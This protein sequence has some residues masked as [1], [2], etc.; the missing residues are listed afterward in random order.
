MDSTRSRYPRGDDLDTPKKTDPR[1][2]EEIDRLFEKNELNAAVLAELKKKYAD[3]EEFLDTILDIY[4]ERSV[5]INREA[6]K[7][8]N[9]IVANGL[10]DK[11]SHEEILKKMLKY[12]KKKGYSDAQFDRFKRLI[13]KEISY[14]SQYQPTYGTTNI[15][16]SRLNKVLGSEQQFLQGMNVAD[17][18]LPIVNEI[19]D[20][21]DT[22][23]KLHRDVMRHALLYRDCAIE[24]I[25]G[26]FDRAKHYAA[27]YADPVFVALFIPRIAV[28][29]FIF[30]FS[31]I[32]RIIK[33]RYQKKSIT[34]AADKELFDQ[35]LIDPNDLICEGVSPLDD[36]RNRYQVQI[37]LWRL[38]LKLRNGLFFDVDTEEAA[39]RKALMAC[40][41]SFFDTS[42]NNTLRDEANLLKKFFSAFSFRPTY[43]TYSDYQPMH[44][45]INDNLAF[46][47]AGYVAT[48]TM[49]NCYLPYPRTTS[50]TDIQSTPVTLDNALN[51]FQPAVTSKHSHVPTQQRVIFSRGIII[52]NVKRRMISTS[53]SGFAQKIPFSVLPIAQSVSS[54]DKIN[55]TPV[56]YQD[57]MDIAGE[58][59]ILR[60]VVCVETLNPVTSSKSMRVPLGTNTSALLCQR[61]D[62]DGALK[63]SST[64]YYQYDP[65]RAAYAI[66]NPT[67]DG[68]YYSN[69]PI[70]SIEPLNFDTSQDQPNFFTKASTTGTIFIY[71]KASEQDDG[72]CI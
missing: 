28:V 12:K 32:G 26:K 62:F 36:L 38:V 39:V 30:L 11:M 60:S 41:A 24:A 7:M 47:A 6:I 50:D 66:K 69:K 57:A 59:F 19:I 43:I 40:R 45:A 4:N 9:F 65:F 10:L 34:E 55:E 52:F 25:T 18:D 33:T 15:N 56:H 20:L 22:N 53:I 17:K 72:L 37:H 35:M 51:Q 29:D 31:N 8:A 61:Y 68:T 71:S 44:T 67:N 13:Q 63:I 27:N 49:V 23:E 48:T 54:I 1:L 5:Q 70:T 21:C 42:D 58:R 64:E 16:R 46:G 14:D 3:D 2:K